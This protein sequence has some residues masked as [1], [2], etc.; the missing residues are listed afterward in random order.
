M[1]KKGD[2]MKLLTIVSV[3]ALITVSGCMQTSSGNAVY[4]TEGSGIVCGQ[5]SGGEKQTFPSIEELSQVSDAQYLHDGP[6]Y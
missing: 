5:L 1:L 4:H 2:I 3:V 6:C